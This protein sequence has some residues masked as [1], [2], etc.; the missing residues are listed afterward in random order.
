MWV[1][2]SRHFV[3]VISGLPFSGHRWR[4]PPHWPSIFFAVSGRLGR[5]Q[6]DVA[7]LDR[8][9][10]ARKLRPVANVGLHMIALLGAQLPLPRGDSEDA[11]LM[12]TTV[13]QRSSASARLDGD[14]MLP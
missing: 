2:A 3:A 14:G 11:R 9:Q 12:A 6:R 10:M 13:I 1:S 8:H 5:D 7:G 4:A